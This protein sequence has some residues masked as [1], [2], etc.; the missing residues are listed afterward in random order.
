[1]NDKIMSQ[2]TSIRSKK[3]IIPGDMH[4]EV[5]DRTR[6]A[7]LFVTY[8]PSESIFRVGIELAPDVEVSEGRDEDIVTLLETKDIAS[9]ARCCGEAVFVMRIASNKYACEITVARARAFDALHKALK[10]TKTK[11]TI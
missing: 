9:A 11:E 7:Q 6:H 10:N 5:I 1:M 4:F 2:L 8:T 3:E